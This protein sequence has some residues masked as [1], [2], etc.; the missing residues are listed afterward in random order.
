[1]EDDEHQREG[2]DGG[3]CQHCKNENL[4]ESQSLWKNIDIERVTCLNESVHERYDLPIV[5][6]AKYVVARK[7]FVLG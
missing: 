5:F 2:H 1:M 7:C 4:G 6:S 3:N